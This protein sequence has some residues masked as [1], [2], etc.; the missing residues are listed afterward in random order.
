MKFLHISDLHIGRKIYNYSLISNQENALNQIIELIEK[1]SIKS[2]LISGDIYDKPVPSAEAVTLFDAFLT[3][4]AK[5]ELNI[6]I[7]SGN[8]DSP[9]R[10]Q[11]GNQ[12]LQ[13]QNIH[14]LGKFQG[15]LEKTSLNDE[16]GKI[17]IYMLPFVKNA[18]FSSFFPDMKFHDISQAIEYL[19]NIS[20]INV[21][22]RNIILYHGFVLCNSNEPETSDSE[23][24]LGGLQ[25]VN[26]DIFEKFDY[27]ALGHIHKPQWVRKNK[28]RYSGSILKYSFSESQQQ[29]SVTVIDLKE[30]DNIEF[31]FYQL[32]EV[33]DMKI[34][35]G[36]F[37]DL[38]ENAL[39]S[40]DF[41]RAEL[42]DDSIVPYAMEKMRTVYPHLLEL[43]Y[44][45]QA[46]RISALSTE[47]TD[48]ENKSIS[49]LL[50]L[51]FNN[52]YQYNIKDEPE[53]LEILNEICGEEK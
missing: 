27:T 25:L 7:I 47:S 44:L 12:L 37:D 38:L 19:I 53:T 48:I 43:I 26:A 15:K 3:K 24:Q 28:I 22:E 32:N 5:M 52:V 4:L 51:F 34:I 11:F 36:R 20:D 42:A 33:Q 50:E 41:I 18:T 35:R 39:P 13:S 30:K 40:D 16:F 31:S 14:I 29:K 9:E 6:F 17:N 46:E 45:K 2:V 49:E 1:E 8:H 21:S 23:L 10:I